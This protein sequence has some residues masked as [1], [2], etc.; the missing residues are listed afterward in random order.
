[1][2]I[3]KQAL[4]IAHYHKDGKLRSDTIDLLKNCE[5]YFK[6]IIFVSTNIQ[7]QELNNLPSFVEFHVREN[8]GYDFF[9]YK[10]GLNLLE[11]DINLQDSH[12][13]KISLVTT[14]NTSFLIFD[15]QKFIRS[16][17]LDGLQENKGDFFGLTMHPKSG[18]TPAHL[19]SFLLS[20]SD[21]VLTDQRVVNWWNR[22]SIFEEKSLIIKK[23]EMGISKYLNLLGYELNPI[24]RAKPIRK[25]LDPTHDNY[26]EILEQFSI[27]KIG[28][29]LNNPSKM[30][31]SAL[32]NRIKQ[33]AHFKSLIIE[34]MEN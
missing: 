20:F 14:L 21:K 16:Y 9:S 17:F 6:R 25:A 30:N 7:Q 34:G 24:Y 1:M 15:P 31:L 2:Q 8:Y 28:F 13:N 11:N 33:N 23:Y 27:L 10:Y 3:K 32:N 18:A 5:K 29:Y 22:L 19:Q 12:P 4:V 26:E